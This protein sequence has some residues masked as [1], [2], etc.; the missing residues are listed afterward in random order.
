MSIVNG[1]N[2]RIMRRAEVLAATGY[3]RAWIYALMRQGKFPLAR[4]IGA[5]AVGW[6]SREIEAWIAERLDEPTR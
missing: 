6:D 5:R 1:T 2:R 3:C 4:K